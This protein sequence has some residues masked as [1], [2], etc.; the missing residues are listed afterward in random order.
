VLIIFA[1]LSIPPPSVLRPR[2]A[3]GIGGRGVSL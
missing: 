1:F 3:R 2:P